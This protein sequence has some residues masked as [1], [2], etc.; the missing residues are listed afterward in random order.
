M[1]IRNNREDR[2]DSEERNEDIIDGK[3]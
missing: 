2:E 1:L 3:E